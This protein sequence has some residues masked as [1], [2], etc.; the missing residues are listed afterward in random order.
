MKVPAQKQNQPQHQLS[1]NITR[2]S[3]KPFAPSQTLHPILN[4]Q[5]TIGNQAIRQLLS[6]KTEDREAGSDAS[7]TT[8]IAQDFSRLPVYSKTAVSPRAKLTVSTPG[9]VYSRKLTRWQIR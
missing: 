1:S 8:H 3:V 5:R 4:L 6:A 2:S 9:D 7:T